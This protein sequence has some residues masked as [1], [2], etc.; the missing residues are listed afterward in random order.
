MKPFE[1][2]F[3][4]ELARAVPTTSLAVKVHQFAV[5]R[6]ILQRMNTSVIGYA[7]LPLALV[8]GNTFFLTLADDAWLAILERTLRLS[9]IVDVDDCWLAAEKIIY[10]H[11]PPTRTTLNELEAGSDDAELELYDLIR[12]LPDVDLLTDVLW[13][14][15]CFKTSVLSEILVTS[16]AVRRLRVTDGYL[17]C[18]LA[19]DA[20]SYYIQRFVSPSWHL[21]S[22]VLRDG[23]FLIKE[24]SRPRTQSSLAQ[25]YVQGRIKF[26]I[27]FLKAAVVFFDSVSSFTAS[28][29]IRICSLRPLSIFRTPFPVI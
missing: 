3:A 6:S 22:D 28:T 12:S 13:S 19:P 10:E 18:T 17:R 11:L 25:R 8:V 15:H 5:E 14:M 1:A 2:A 9:T 16:S 21:L 26:E 24:L 27:D 4:A 23:S 29:P 20:M 7:D